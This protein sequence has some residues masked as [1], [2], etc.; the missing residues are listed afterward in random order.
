MKLKFKIN[1]KD[2]Q[3]LKG[4]LMF[5]AK[6]RSF[7]GFHKKSKILRGKVN[8][9]IEEKYLKKIYTFEYNEKKKIF[10]SVDKW[11]KYIHGI[12]PKYKW[13]KAELLK[14]GIYISRFEGLIGKYQG[15]EWLLLHA[16]RFDP[17]N[18]SSY[19]NT[20]SN[21][22]TYYIKKTGDKKYTFADS[23]WIEFDLIK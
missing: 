18:K 3:T 21:Q 15:Y 13:K 23:C 7:K 20:L 2:S 9:F 12:Y 11:P 4:N 14:S 17:F 22:I 10:K 8:N 19:M 1:I 6:F 16:V 5:P